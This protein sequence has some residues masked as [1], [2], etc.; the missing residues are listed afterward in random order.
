MVAAFGAPVGPF[1]RM[2]WAAH[3]LRLAELLTVE[4]RRAGRQRRQAVA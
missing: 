1:W 2:F 4:L 3:R